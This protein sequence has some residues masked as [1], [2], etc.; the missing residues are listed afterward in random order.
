MSVRVRVGV[1]RRTGGLVPDATGVSETSSDSDLPD[2]TVPEGVVSREDGRS[3]D[4][5]IGHGDLVSEV[6]VTDLGGG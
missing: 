5:G 2:D 6:D 1:G 3:W 4:Q